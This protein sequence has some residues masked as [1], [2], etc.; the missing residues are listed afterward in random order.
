[1]RV[2]TGWLP[3]QHG[4]WAMLIVPFVVGLEVRLRAGAG[5]PPFV[6]SLL[7]TW[8]LAYFAFNAASLWL[9]APTVR[10]RALAAPLAVYA[11]ASGACGV[12][13]VTLAGPA[14]LLWAVPYACL[15][16][17]ALALAARRLDRT[18]IGG[19][20]TTAAASL[21]TLV[22][23][24]PDPRALL[25]GDPPAS[26]AVPAA[27]LVFAYFFGTVLYVKTNIRERGSRRFYAASVG[28]HGLVTLGCAVLA[29]GGLIGSGWAVLFAAATAR[30]AIVPRLRPRPS[31][32]RIGLLEIGFCAALCAV[33]IN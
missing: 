24:F 17:P 7:G 10:R 32:L 13:T 3:R 8:L 25:A 26:A 16:A 11:L 6:W 1:M 20:L 12:A 27:F 29:G 15:A 30:A 23:V 18:T 9:R 22:V 5:A 31:P 14:L 4:A 33:A 21:L 19:A 2:K 28:W